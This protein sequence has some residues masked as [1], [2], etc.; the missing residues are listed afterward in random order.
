MATSSLMDDV[1]GNSYEPPVDVIS[2]ATTNHMAEDDH[3]HYM[4]LENNALVVPINGYVTP[5]IVIITLATNCIVCAVLLRPHMRSPTNALLVA[6]ATSDML[7]GVWSVPGFTYFY[8]GNAYQDWV[9]YQWCFVYTVL[10]EYIPTMF[11]T[12]SIWLTVTLAVQRYVYVC[13]ALSARQ[14]CTTANFVR[15]I[16][17]VFLA[18]FLSQTS[19]FFENSF[20]EAE[21]P[22]KL[23]VNQVRA[24]FCILL[25]V[26]RQ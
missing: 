20:T 23:V 22:S 3:Y 12:A 11:H 8:T 4:L 7:T 14:L 9:P 6:I 5:I 2:N 19:R 13:R 16:C 15:I 18:A 17:G 26:H 10:T 25:G 24:R 21:L 1:G